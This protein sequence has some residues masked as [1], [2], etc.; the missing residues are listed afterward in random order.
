MAAE[1]ATAI[2]R[3]TALRARLVSWSPADIAT[4]RG[5]LVALADEAHAALLLM[6]RQQ[7][8]EVTR[9]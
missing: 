7:T 8:G 9:G 2:D 6:R 4:N 5:H 1:L 3:V